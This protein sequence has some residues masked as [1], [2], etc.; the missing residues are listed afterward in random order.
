MNQRQLKYFLEV[1]NQKCI[2]SAARS[3]YISPQGLS[4]TIASLE[5]ELKVS[6]F[7]HSHNRI[8]PTK[9][10]VQLAAHAKNILDEYELISN[11]LFLTQNPFKMLTIYCSYDVPQLIPADFFYHFHKEYPEI[12]LRLREYPDNEILSSME[13]GSTELSIFPGPFD[14][15]K[16][17]GDLLFCEPFCLVVNK[18]H[19]LA[20]KKYI[21]M[22]EI[23]DEAL[24]VK[25][26]SSQTSLH[27]IQ[28]LLK[29]GI[30]VNIMLEVS[31]AHLIHQMA[32]NN[33]AIGM[34]LLYLA[35][36]I[37]SEKIR[38]LRFE[39]KWMTKNLFLVHDKN[40]FLSY[41]ASVFRQALL[42]YCSSFCPE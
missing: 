24:V 34:S 1:Y 8:T 38:I 28:D 17:N 27:Q 41:E 15:E 10:A 20:K 9:Y 23:K 31:D 14:T 12:K 36:K 40:N 6:L 30:D 37:R 33:Y 35:K 2:S 16:M 32:E 5:D 4:K 29:E 42:D 25:D 22:S 21:S 3:L 11:K 7:V 18:E 26:M 19:P 39:E 13:N